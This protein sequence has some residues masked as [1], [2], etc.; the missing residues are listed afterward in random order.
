MVNFAGYVDHT[1]KSK[2]MDSHYEGCRNLAQIFL[3]KKLKNLFKLVPVLSMGRLD[4]H[5]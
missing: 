5:K 4:R 2:T 3:K 1:N